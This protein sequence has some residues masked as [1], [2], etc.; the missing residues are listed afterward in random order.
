MEFN[1]SALRKIFADAELEVPKD[2]LGQL[3]DL[4]TESLD[5]MGDTIKDLKNQLKTAEKERDEAKAKAPDGE[6]V[7]KAEYDKIKKDFEDYKGQIA[8]KETQA[9]KE[10]AVRA[11]YEG[12]NITG[13]DLDVAMRGSAAEIAALE[14]VDGKIKDSKALDDLV[15]GIFSGLVTDTR[16]QGQQQHNPAGNGGGNGGEINSLRAALHAKFDPKG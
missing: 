3:C 7:S 2:V 15:S 4:H 10:K 6:I 12:K 11:Y 14:L 9:A 16:Q 5:G 8:A 13:K 1:R